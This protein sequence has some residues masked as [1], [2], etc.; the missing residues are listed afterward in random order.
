[1]RA[2]GV[3]VA[4]GTDSRASNPD[5]N[6][7][8]ELRYVWQQQLA[9]TPAEILQMATLHGAEAL[10]LAGDAGSLSEGKRAD[11]IA[12]PCDAERNDPYE[13]VFGGADKPQRVWLGGR[14]GGRYL[15]AEVLENGK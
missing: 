2:A 6:L 4:L 9:P 3:R 10:G 13:A 5:L 7:L 1:M 15:S 14:E 12:L 11:M 8:I